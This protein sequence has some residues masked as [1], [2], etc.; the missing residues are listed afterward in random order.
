MPDHVDLYREFLGY[1]T[2]P[3]V[4]LLKSIT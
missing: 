4:M 3:D 2:K 1:L